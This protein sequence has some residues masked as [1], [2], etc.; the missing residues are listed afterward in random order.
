MNLLPESSL[1]VGELCLVDLGPLFGLFKLGFELVNHCVLELH[2][3]LDDVLLGLHLFPLL[4]DESLHLCIQLLL[5]LPH[6]TVLLLK[7]HCILRC[8]R[9]DLGYVRL[10]TLIVM[11]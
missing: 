8:L 7:T 1:A 5:L 11:H 6:T 2:V 3:S 9:L 4:F 10:L